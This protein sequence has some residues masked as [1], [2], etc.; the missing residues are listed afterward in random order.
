MIHR[1]VP[2]DTETARTNS[3]RRVASS[4]VGQVTFF[5]S[6]MTSPTNLNRPPLALGSPEVGRCKMLPLPVDLERAMLSHFPMK[7]AASTPGTELVELQAVRVVT[8]ILGG[9]VGTLSAF[10][11]T[12]RNDYPSSCFSL[13]HDDY[14]ITLVTTPDPTVLP[15]SRMA[16]RS[17]FSRTMGEMSFRVISMLSPGITIST[18]SGNLISPVTSVVRRKN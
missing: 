4:R 11:T 18:P 6:L 1:A 5:S 17:P 7:P 12:Q 16:N 3:V 14:S 2:T 13:G 8:P 9:C 10:G 15:P